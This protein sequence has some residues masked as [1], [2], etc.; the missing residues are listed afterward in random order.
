[1]SLPPDIDRI[2]FVA[3]GMPD[4][5]A[6]LAALTAR[7]GQVAPEEAQMIVALGGDGLMLQT[8]HNFMGSGKPIYGMHRGT[9]GFLM[10]DYCEE[11]LK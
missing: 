2:A 11:N 6:A 3:S 9:V 8:L 7:Y 5:Q 1:M 4:A 10:N